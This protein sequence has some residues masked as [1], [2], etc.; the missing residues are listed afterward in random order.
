MIVSQSNSLLCAITFY[1]MKEYFTPAERL[2]VLRAGDGV[3]K[4]NSL[5]DERVC[6]VCDRMFSGRQIHISRTQRGR[7]L[8]QCPTEGCPSFVAH[9]FYVGN[10]GTA[11]ENILLGPDGH[12]GITAWVVS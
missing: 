11:T 10:T 9:W 7:Y 8:L 5:D 1:G 12:N 6:V 2:E 3:R 4:W